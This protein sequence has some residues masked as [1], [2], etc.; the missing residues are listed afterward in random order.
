LAVVDTVALLNISVAFLVVSVVSGGWID[1]DVCTSLLLVS[2][3][4]EVFKVLAILISMSSSSFIG[5]VAVCIIIRVVLVNVDTGSLVLLVSAA[6]GVGRELEIMNVVLFVVNDVEYSIVDCTVLDFWDGWVDMDAG[7]TMMLV[8]AT[9]KVGW[10]FKVMSS[11]VVD[12]VASLVVFNVLLDVFIG[13]V[14]ADLGISLLFVSADLEIKVGGALEVVS[15]AVV[16]EGVLPIVI[17]CVD[18]ESDRWVDMDVV[19]SMLLV[20]ATVEVSGAREV[21]DSS[22]FDEFA[23][24]EIV[25]VVLVF[26]GWV[27][28]ETFS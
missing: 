3:A 14:N 17:V 12:D 19:N 26:G 13:S 27:N 16:D 8:S 5:T 25:R 22:I 4:V 21:V 28:I 1:V 10:A 15:S 2:A 20:S 9:V 18:P 11:T 24:P 23:S 7:S 6:V